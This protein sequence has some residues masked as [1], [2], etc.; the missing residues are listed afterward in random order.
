VLHDFALVTTYLPIL[1]RTLRAALLV[2]FMYWCMYTVRIQ[3]PGIIVFSASV[4]YLD[5][6]L[7]RSQLDQAA[8]HPCLC[9]LAM[10]RSSSRASVTLR[11]GD[12]MVWR[13]EVRSCRKKETEDD[14]DDVFYL[15]LQ[16]QKSAQRYIPQGYFP[17]YEAV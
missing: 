10:L 17:P 14:E 4:V 7:L 1:G 3:F 11:S 8:S 15:F 2:S 5:S 16:K 12:M 9:E 6:L 13:Y